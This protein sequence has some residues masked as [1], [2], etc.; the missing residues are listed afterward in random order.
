MTQNNNFGQAQTASTSR[1]R[2]AARQRVANESEKEVS[3]ARGLFF[4]AATSR[5]DVPTGDDYSSVLKAPADRF[6]VIEDVFF[7]VDFSQGGSAGNFVVTLDGYIDESTGNDWNYTPGTPIPLGRPVN[8]GKINDVAQSTIDLGVA[9]NVVSGS[10]DYQFF[11]ADYFLETGGNRNTVTS[12]SSTF[13]GEERKV[14][15][16]PGQEMLARTQTSGTTTGTGT[17]KVLL[18][19]AEVSIEDAPKVLGATLEELGYIP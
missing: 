17:V 6:L 13:F 1:D 16:K 8:A 9:F 3:M 4:T 10:P 12:N 18:F 19:T 14:I 2:D 11:F 7:S 5:P 15:L